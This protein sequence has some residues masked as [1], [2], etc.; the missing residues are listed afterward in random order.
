MFRI[1][2][3]CYLTLSLLTAIVVT[4]L[5]WMGVI[6]ELANGLWGVWAW[7][8]IPWVIIVCINLMNSPKTRY[9]WGRDITRNDWSNW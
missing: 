8:F 3:T 1:I 7:W 4:L 5:Y 2:T 6:L 9:D